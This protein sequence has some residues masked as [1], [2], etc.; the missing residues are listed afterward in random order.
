MIRAAFI[1]ALACTGL[2]AVHQQAMA[3]AAAPVWTLV[4]T[5]STPTARHENSLAAIDGR[6]YLLGGRGERALEMFDPATGQWTPRALP[7]LQM[8]HLQA[9]S[10]N[11]KLYVVSA[12][13]GDFPEEAS[14]SH[15]QIY[16]PVADAWSQGP[17]IPAAR[18]R[19][20]SGVVVHEGLIYVVGGNRRG[21]M[22]GY[23]PWLDVFDP[24]SG[25][26]R[27]LPDAPN[28]RDHFHAAE[29]DGHIYAAGGRR[30]SHDTGEGMSFHVAEVDAYDIAS[31]QWRTLPASLP[32]LRSGA[33]AVAFDG[34]LVVMGGESQSQQRGHAEVERLDVEHGAWSSLPPLPVG[35]HGTQA[36]VV[37]GAVHIVAGSGDAGGGPELSDHY[38]LKAASPH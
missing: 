18:R 38:V 5:G 34:A 17:E 1:A 25:A 20:A 7:P 26:W 11:G 36:V 23:V 35:R 4:E 22:S 28:A 32:T 8:S 9:A 15:V 6:L 24:A 21:H 19:G 14:I 3:Q 29:I 33:A 31:G 12:F 27:S 16:D 2:I 30:S 13:I 10:L 37:D